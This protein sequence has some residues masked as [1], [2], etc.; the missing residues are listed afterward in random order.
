MEAARS[1]NLS[2]SLS[3]GDSLPPIGAAAPPGGAAAGGG[4]GEVGGETGSAVGGE[5]TVGLGLGAGAPDPLDEEEL[6]GAA[7]VAASSCVGRG[8]TCISTKAV[9]HQ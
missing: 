9:G 6:A 4:E 8:L 3:V 7:D 2:R 1:R 5:G